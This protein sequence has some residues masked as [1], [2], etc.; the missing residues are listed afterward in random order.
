MSMFGG[1]Y[2]AMRVAGYSASES[3]GATSRTSRAEGRARNL[4]ARLEK[5][6]LVCAAMWELLREKTGLT[7]E[8][9]KVCVRQID[10]V[11]GR[12][13]GKVAKTV[14]RCAKCDRVMSARHTRCLYCGAE[15]LEATAFDSV[16]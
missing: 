10:L 15:S 1:L 8:D 13:D 14:S 4:E 7:E 5:L 16:L 2:G 11:D 9:L 3:V 12:A 6:S